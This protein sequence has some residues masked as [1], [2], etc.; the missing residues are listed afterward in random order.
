[1]PSGLRNRDE[2]LRNPVVLWAHQRALP[3]IGVCRGLEVRADRIVAETEFARGVPFA[4]DVFRLYE[5]GIL[6]AWSIGFVPKRVAPLRRGQRIDEWDLLE[7]SAVPV[8][9]NPAALT[10]A[11]RKGIVY[12]RGDSEAL[13]CEFTVIDGPH[14]K[15]K[16]WTLMTVNGAQEGHHKAAEISAGEGHDMVEHIASLG[17][18][19]KS[20]T[21]MADVVAEASNRH[22]EQLPMAKANL[23]KL[24]T[25]CPQGCEEREDLAEA[26]A[27]ASKSAN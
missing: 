4:E 15:R 2:F 16:F 23:A 6:R 14:T 18:Y 21:Y 5:Q 19:E 20:L 11:V 3:P 17:P 24:E 9:E 25:L 26:I 12:E 8:P 13:D 10:L 7:Y 27:A 22:G 1:M